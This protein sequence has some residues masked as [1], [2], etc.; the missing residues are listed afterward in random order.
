MK[1][2]ISELPLEE[3]ERIR[4]YNREQKQKSREKQKTESYNP[5]AD[6]WTDSFAIDFP[7]RAKELRAYAKAF[8]AKVMEELGGRKL[9]CAQ[10]DLSGNVTGW[11]N[12]EEFTVNRVAWLSLS[13][14]NNWIQKVQEGELFGGLYFADCSGSMVES[15]NRHSLKNSPTFNT[16]YIELL[17]MLDKRY[18]CEQTKDA[19]II[20]AELA[21][22]YG[23]RPMSS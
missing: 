4:K 9:G 12:D 23:K 16:A 19:A 18:G 2:R 22:T 3:Q 14:K 17:K 11:D 1:K 5:S 7:E 10:K 15:A 20:Q 6:E 8:A 13:L 21:G